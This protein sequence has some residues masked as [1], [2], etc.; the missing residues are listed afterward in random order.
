MA[1]DPIKGFFTTSEYHALA[2]AGIIAED[3]RLELIEGEIFRM[4]PIGS[5]HA[6][7]VN[8]LTR[9]LVEGLRGRAILAPQNPVCLN[10]YSEPQ[11][12]LALLHPREDDYAAAHPLPG[13]VL[14]LIEVADATLEHDRRKK[15]PLYARSGIADV[16]LIDLT[17]G[18]VEVHRE[19]TGQG[20][21][22]V[23]RLRR[24][25]SL[26]PL[27]FPD[28]VLDVSAIVG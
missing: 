19:P 22:D 6:G 11:P 1:T 28:L 16:W 21:A 18:I 8:R 24:G 23:R 2:E 25:Q 26:A 15:V 17:Q 5:R 3:E 7:C 12:D 14:L 13:E 10:D 9:L 27:A 4:A 20:Y